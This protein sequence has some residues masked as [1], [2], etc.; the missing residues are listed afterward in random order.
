MVRKELA[1]F[2][3]GE[4]IMPTERSMIETLAALV[5]EQNREGNR[6]KTK[7]GIA[8][9]KVRK[10]EMRKR[11]LDRAFTAYAQRTRDFPVQP[12]VSDSA[13]EVRHGKEYAVLRNV[14][15]VLAVY[16]YCKGSD[17]LRFIDPNAEPDLFKTLSVW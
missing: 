7:A 15:G 10:A 9:A 12:S 13:F 1:S 16:R 5:L 4:D 11:I 3:S 8:Y 17:S 14:N 2:S 6:Q